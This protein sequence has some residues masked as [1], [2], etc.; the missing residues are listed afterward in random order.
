MLPEV[1]V[2]L[3]PEVAVDLAP[4]VVLVDLARVVRP[5]RELAVEGAWWVPEWCGRRSVGIGHREEMD[6]AR[7]DGA[8]PLVQADDDLR[9]RLER[10][11][12][13]EELLCAK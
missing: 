10:R 11:V 1:A 9:L 2:D 5:A 8:E 6:G 12:L 4:E 13:G 3:A 7:V